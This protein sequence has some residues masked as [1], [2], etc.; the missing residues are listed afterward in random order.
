[1]YNNKAIVIRA[2]SSTETILF[3]M[4]LKKSSNK[5]LALAEL[6]EFE[7]IQFDA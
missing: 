2:R 7:Q 5:S 4:T 1:M 6:C 3:R